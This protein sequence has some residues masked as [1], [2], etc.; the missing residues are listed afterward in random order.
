[1]KIRITFPKITYEDISKKL[2]DIDID[3]YESEDV[4]E[5]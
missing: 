4:K 5:K 2:V 1:M 3:H